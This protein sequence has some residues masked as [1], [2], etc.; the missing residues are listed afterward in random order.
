MPRCLQK[1]SRLLLVF[2]TTRLHVQFSGKTDMILQKSQYTPPIS[3]IRRVP[4]RHLPQFQLC[5]PATI[6]FTVDLTIVGLSYQKPSLYSFE[7]VPYH[8]LDY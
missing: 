8:K 6:P 1:H 5:P 7:C 4:N 3:T 2:F